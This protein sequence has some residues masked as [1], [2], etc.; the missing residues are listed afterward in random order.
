MGVLHGV[1]LM[2]KACCDLYGI[3]KL[4][5]NVAV[6]GPDGERG[7]CLK[8]KVFKAMVLFGLN[9]MSRF[10]VSSKMQLL[11]FVVSLMSLITQV[12]FFLFADRP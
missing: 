9:R 10:N 7:V 8:G 3:A 2:G 5:G 6:V 1:S 11:S 4:V 12:Q